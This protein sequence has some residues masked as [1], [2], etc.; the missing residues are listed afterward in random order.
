MSPVKKTSAAKKPAAK[1]K[2]RTKAETKSA[3]TSPATRFVR[4]P[5]TKPFEP[6]TPAPSVQKPIAPPPLPPRPPAP[7]QAP[8]VASQAMNRPTMTTRP[9]NN[10]NGYGNRFDGQVDGRRIPDAGMPT[11]EVS[12]A[13]DINPD[14]HGLIRAKYSRSDKDAYISSSQIRRFRLRRGDIISGPARKP[15]DNERYW[16]LLKVAKVNGKDP[17]KMGERRKFGNLTPIYP[18]KQ[19]ILETKPEILSTRMIDLVTPVGFGQRGIIVSPPKAGKT[20]ILKE[21]S[22]GVAVNHPKAHLMACL[23]GERPEEVTDIREHIE[24][25][26]KGKGE[27]AASNFDEAPVEQTRVAEV[28]LQRAKRLVEE[29]EDVIMVMDSITRLARAYNLAMP[30][31]GRTLSG[32]FDPAAL[33]PPKGFFGA[34]RNFKEKGS[35]T[36]LGT[37][38]IDT[39]SRMDDLIY[40]EFKGTGNLEL[41]LDRHLADRRIYPAIDVQRSGTRKEE[42][43][44]TATQ[45]QSII[46]MRR[47]IDLLGKDERTSIL[48]ERLRKTKNNKEFLAGLKEG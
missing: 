3:P 16:G 42:L 37:A 14:G 46:I 28:A 23:I 18:D 5:L 4:K 15:K 12:G 1:T 25:V 17:F 33:H 40:E 32:G 8:S 19:M 27:V 7:T 36:I 13:L 20:T 2:P 43:L 34:A 47:M 22:S 41:H 39:G 48:I 44:F 10:H 35:L 45:Y 11:E 31:S 6:T 29:G 24:T 38:L 26:T 21:I 9:V 30:T